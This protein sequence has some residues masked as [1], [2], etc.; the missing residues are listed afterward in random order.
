VTNV[1]LCINKPYN[2]T[3]ND[4]GFRWH[5]GGYIINIPE[6]E[7]ITFVYISSSLHPVTEIKY[8]VRI[9]SHMDNTLVRTP[10]YINMGDGINRVPLNLMNIGAF[11]IVIRGFV[12]I[13]DRLTKDASV[14]VWSIQDTDVLYTSLIA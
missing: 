6:Y 12:K 13:P 2:I 1:S 9:L 14:S 11:N 4:T 5:D 7:R 8:A 3:F 10:I